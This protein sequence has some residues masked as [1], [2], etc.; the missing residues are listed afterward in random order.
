M[1]EVVDSPIHL[2]V[3]D[4]VP[5]RLGPANLVL[6]HTDHND[7]S[8]VSDMDNLVVGSNRHSSRTRSFH[9][10]RMG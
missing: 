1:V 10:N 5:G 2:A 8:L 3:A 6:E 9:N 7:S 4:R